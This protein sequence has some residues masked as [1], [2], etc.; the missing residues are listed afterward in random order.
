MTVSIIIPVFNKLEFTRQCLDRIRR[1]TA[2][3]D[4]EV[5]VVDNGSSD[6]TREWFS[7]PRGPA[8]GVRY[9]RHDRN[10]GFAQANNTGARLAG[11]RYLL[12]LNNDTL[13][14]P[15]WLTSMVALRESDA[16]IGVVGIK[17]LF[18]YT[19]I[20][21]H[22]GIVFGPDGRPEHLYPHLDASLPQ[23]NRQ[24]EYQA[25]MGA[26]LLIDRTLFEDCGGFDEHY[27]NGYEDVDLCLSVTQ[28]GR[29]V[30]C[31]TDAYIYHYGQISEGRTASDDD[32]AALFARKWAGHVRPDRD[33]YLLRDARESARASGSSRGSIA[34]LPPECIYLADDLD[35]GSA[36]TWINAELALALHELGAPVLVNG[37]R[38]LS[39]TLSAAARQKLKPLTVSTAP[40]GGVQIK[41]SHY[42]SRHLTLELAGDVNFELFVINYVFGA[43]GVEPWDRWLQ[44]LRQN[45]HAKIALSEFCADVLGQA[46][47]PEADRVVWHP[48]YAREVL[49]GDATTRHQSPFRFLTVTNSHDL[50]RYNT[51]AIVDAFRRT[52]SRRDDVV[53]VVKD[54]G[55]SSGN[56]TL[57]RLLAANTEGPRIEYIDRFTDKRDLVGLY[58]SCHAFVS[59]HRGEGFGMKILDAMACGLPIVTP[60]FGGPTDF[61]TPETAVPVEFSLIPMGDCLDTRSLSITNHPLWAEVDR[62]D[63]GLQMR[64]VFED[65][66]PA[67]DVADRARDEVLQRFS[68][69]AAAARFVELTTNRRLAR[70]AGRSRRPSGAPAAS[71]ARGSVSPYWLGLRVSVVIPT[72]NRKEKLLRCLDALARQSV[73]PQEFEVIVV[74][75]GSADGTGD[76]LASRVFP[77]AMQYCR[78]EAAGPGAA[79][80]L[81]LER[82]GGE[83]VLFMGDDTYADERLL[84][85]HLLAHARM[86]AHGVA[87]LGHIDWL[88]GV[89]PNAVM[90][91][92]CG[93][94]MLQFAYSYI[95]SAPDLDHRF[96]Y[97]SNISLKRRFLIDAA[98]AGIRFDPC[99]RRAAFEDSE[100]AFRLAP[101][102]LRL[103]YAPDARVVHDHWMDLDSFTQREF[104]AGEMAV[105]FFRKHPIL[106]DELRV[107]SVDAVFPAARTLL[108]RPAVLQQLEA[109]DRETDKALRAL[110]VSYEA[111]GSLGRQP[112]A[113]STGGLPDDRLRGGL[114]QLFDI[115]FD[116]ARTRGKIQEW[117][118]DSTDRALCGAAQTL[119][120][121]IRKLEF[122]DRTP[123]HEVLRGSTTLD[124]DAMA[125]LRAH[126]AGLEIP[127][128]DRGSTDGGSFGSRAFRRILMQPAVLGR[129]LSADR[130]IQ[131]RL[132]GEKRREWLRRYLRV[133][134]GVG[135]SLR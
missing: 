63:L 31:C 98:D 32:N 51:S 121:V 23:V 7:H 42:R 71:P 104:R 48:G 105:V 91:Y 94:A 46:G 111:L 26:C 2:A 114:H 37:R 15:D 123:Q 38:P 96:F 67:Q 9:H 129:L 73:L 134:A 97:T 128:P 117:C 21:Y 13:V 50:E 18:P 99:F 132:Q 130:A 55:A 86:P 75:D 106:D 92:V 4:Y 58:R 35:Q 127:V 41:W 61:C 81:G 40:V 125:N 52:F 82:A 83:L 93:D 64:R 102:G 19:N 120:S 62:N 59:A 47:V 43:P 69:A 65:P 57:R 115:V 49:E 100:F 10:L 112:G 79:R 109:F 17:Q 25:V 6:G 77:F 87:V 108:G 44:C 16:A 90:E 53:L 80:N 45:H 116:I 70:L 60:L 68:W 30:Y 107:G 89:E 56:Q 113:E 24:R 85:Q 20:I 36:L 1:N 39:T 12:F 5:I 11:G 131:R 76:V 110:A 29:K 28:R 78:Q 66:A 74:D 122:F 14:Q 101:R 72:R 88:P 34:T 84:E 54:Y 33:A 135:R 126:M 8:A 133:R 3:P 27:R 124:A 95:A 103:V 118:S 22:T 119:A